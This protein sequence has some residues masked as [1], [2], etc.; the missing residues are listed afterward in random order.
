LNTGALSD[1]LAAPGEKRPVKE[2]LGVAKLSPLLWAVL[3]F[4]AKPALADNVTYQQYSA[5]SAEWKRGFV[6]A[7]AQYH[8]TINPAERP[9]YPTTR[10]F[11]RCLSGASDAILQQQV[12]T[13]VARNPSSLTEPM[14]VVVVKTLHDMCRAEMGKGG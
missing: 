9:P 12:E 4:V 1:I 11:Q 2:G 10:A 14:V 8:T 3:V 13:Y 5:S 7:L 6:F